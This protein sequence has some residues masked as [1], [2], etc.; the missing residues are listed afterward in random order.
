MSARLSVK[1]NAASSSAPT[2]TKT[3]MTYSEIKSLLLSIDD[4]VLKLETLMDLGRELR[5]IPDGRAGD[6]I[7]GCASRVE[8]WRSPDGGIFC[9]ADSA[10]V[11]GIAAVLIAMKNAG[12]DFSEFQSLGLNLGAARITGSRAMID[13]LNNMC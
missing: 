5:P 9:N 11:R 8:V 6:E 12:A 1:T 7:K 4:P 13:Y 10:L 3:K 2:Q